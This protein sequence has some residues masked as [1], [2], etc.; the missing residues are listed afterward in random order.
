MDPQEYPVVECDA[1]ELP[2]V[3]APE[4]VLY[5]I[6][7]STY[8]EPNVMVRHGDPSTDLAACEAFAIK[9]MSAYDAKEAFVCTVH[10]AYAKETNVKKVI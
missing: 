9:L 2:P 3:P 7:Y 6:I 1:Q 4:T 10:A 5:Q 8:A